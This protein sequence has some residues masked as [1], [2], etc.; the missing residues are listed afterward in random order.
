MYLEKVYRVKKAEGES[1]EGNFEKRRSPAASEGVFKNQRFESKRDFCF[2]SVEK[3][4]SENLQ[5][6]RSRKIYELLLHDSQIPFA[7]QN[8]GNIPDR[9]LKK[10]KSGLFIGKMNAFLQHCHF[11]KWF[12]DRPPAFNQEPISIFQLLSVPIPAA[13]AIFKNV[14]L[15]QQ[16]IKN[17]ISN[18]T[19]TE[20][21][22]QR[23]KFIFCSSRRLFFN[24]P[25]GHIQLHLKMNCSS[26]RLGIYIDTSTENIRETLPFIFLFR[27]PE[28]TGKAHIY[29]GERK[30]NSSRR[31]PP[32]FFNMASIV[33]KKGNFF[34]FF[35]IPPSFFKTCLL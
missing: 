23:L 19:A 31:H 13:A 27:I 35:R 25:P 7:F 14:T 17:G 3:N 9:P 29:Q 11:F 33:K 5:R 15:A 22:Y 21:I 24:N 8:A 18:D 20:K 26:S 30:I 4:Y 32:N 2:L 34:S 10:M 12:S 28:N 16:V 1:I 6:E